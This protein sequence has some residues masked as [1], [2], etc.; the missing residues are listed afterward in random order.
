MRIETGYIHNPEYLRWMRTNNQEIQR[1]PLDI[2]L[3]GGNCNEMPSW[4]RINNALI[5]QGIRSGC[6]D[7]QHRRVSHIRHFAME[8]IPREKE[9][10]FVIL[11]TDYL[12]SNIS[13]EQW[14]KKFRMIVKRNKLNQER[15]NVFD[16]YSNGMKDLFINL[17]HTKDY[18]QFRRCAYEI[19]TYSNDQLNKINKKYGSR[20][21]AYSSIRFL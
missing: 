13:E 21:S 10:E 4:T 5:P 18:E 19:E 8:N 14:K 3:D 1:N 11:R 17:E 2:P 16:L 12:L 9:E 6:W 20:D 15:Y 7:E